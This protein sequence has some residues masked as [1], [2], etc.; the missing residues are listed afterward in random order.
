MND[1]IETI[2]TIETT[3]QEVELVE[4]DVLDL[5]HVDDEA[6]ERLTFDVV[7]LVT[8][9]VG[10]LRRAWRALTR[11]AVDLYRRVRRVVSDTRV[12]I[13]ARRTRRAWTYPAAHRTHSRWFG[14]QCSTSERNAT[15]AV[16]SRAAAQEA[17]LPRVPLEFVGWIDNFIETLRAEQDAL[18]P[19]D[20]GR[21]FICS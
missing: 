18:H 1:T 13:Y 2:E 17:D 15:R 10:R 7:P 3:T 20:E 9:R 8:T 21:H 4:S 11:I 6:T 14:R 12:V 19:R 16:V 5:F